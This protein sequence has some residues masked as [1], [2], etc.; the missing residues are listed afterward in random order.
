[1]DFKTLLDQINTLFQNL[2]VKQKAII[3]ASNL[4]V[5][6]FIVFL[7][8]YTNNKD[9][10]NDGYRVLF[11][12]ISASDSA[13][14]IEQLEKDN[15]PYKLLDEGTIKVPKDYVYKER[16]AI[17]ALGIP[18]NSKIG[19][20]LFD[21]QEFGETDFS[22]QIKY[23]RALEG[24]LARTISSL[25]P[26]ED[27]K[28][29]IAIPKESVFV[30][31]ETKPTA[32]VVLNITPNMKLTGKQISG[33]KNLIAA[34]VS[35]LSSESV[36]I[37]NQDGEPL[38]SN[39]TDGFEADMVAAQIKYKNDYERAY[40]EKIVKV[41]APIL[42]SKE[43]VVAKVTIDFDFEQKN[44]VSE[45]YDPESVIRSEQTTEELK[46]G[47]AEQQPGGVPGAI[48]NIGPVEGV[49]NNQNQG[50]KYEK[51]S[52]T[53]NYEI[54]K[55]VTNIK[56]EFARVKR[57]TA[58]VVVDGKY[59]PKKDAEGNPTDEMEYI[60]LQGSDIDAITNIVKNSFGYDEARGDQVTVSNFELNPL[61]DKGPKTL[62]DDINIVTASYITPFLP[63]I[64]YAIAGLLLFVFYKKIIAP[65]GE[66]MLQDY[67]QEEELVEEVEMEDDTADADA[68][69]EYNEAKKKAEEELGLSGPVDKDEIKHEVLLK[70]I[71]AEI[72][73]NPEDA[74][75]L[76]KSIV[77]SDKDF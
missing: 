15:V 61:K 56:G 35:K 38:G 5:I 77:E 73:Q 47:A 16:I 74:A 20:E 11:D 58:S 19:F 7:V 6:G 41:L 29:H 12:N 30:E 50:E 14:V 55:K 59:E 27:A 1:M 28:V 13:L 65:F 24:E 43:K 57:V 36:E 23:L 33:I 3:G 53:T 4:A 71:R 2:S 63:L 45:F 72:E 68:M 52:T 48:S 26:I 40:E 44:T 69:R 17:A 66:R 9:G 51:T 60:A 64:K 31:K 32:S 21:K 42:G 62:V 46:E 70:K 8:L 10:V 54:S 34:S 67:N 49:D 25:T 37:V 18:K 39:A 22:Q 75:K 76:I